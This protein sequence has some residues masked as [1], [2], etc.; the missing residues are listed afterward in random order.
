MP[1]Q[2]SLCTVYCAPYGVWFRIT[3]K[4]IGYDLLYDTVHY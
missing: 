1:K 4:E 2:K 3:T